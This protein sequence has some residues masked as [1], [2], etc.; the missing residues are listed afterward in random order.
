MCDQSRKTD[1][2]TVDALF[3]VLS[4]ERRRIVLEYLLR[5]DG[6]VAVEELVDHIVA[7]SQSLD[8]TQSDDL[9]SQVSLSLHHVHLPKMADAGMAEY[10]RDRGLVESVDATRVV[11]PYLE[12]SEIDNS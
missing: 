9:R 5:Q 12:R 7:K 4:I 6:P 1:D 3:D 2:I 11:E 10:D 8:D